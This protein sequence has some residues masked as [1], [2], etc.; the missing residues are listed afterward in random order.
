M[1]LRCQCGYCRTARGRESRHRRPHWLRETETGKTH[2]A[3]EITKHQISARMDIPTT[4]H[5]PTIM[6]TEKVR[7]FDRRLDPNAQPISG[8]SLAL[9]LRETAAWGVLS[10]DDAGLGLCTGRGILCLLAST[11]RHR[12]KLLHRGKKRRLAGS[13]AFRRLSR[14]R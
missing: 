12:R 11:K 1:K 10:F 2:R 6:R 7:L 14:H 4:S 9:A 5:P 13:G 8:A 3:G